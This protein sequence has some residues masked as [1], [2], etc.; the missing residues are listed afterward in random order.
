MLLS[1]DAPISS[2]WFIATIT[3]SE[4]AI[5]AYFY[6]FY[7]RSFTLIGVKY[8]VN[9]SLSITKMAHFLQF[10][11]NITIAKTTYLVMRDVNGHFG[12]RDKNL[13]LVLEESIHNTKS[14]LK[15]LLWLS[16]TN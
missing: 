16:P 13:Y 3:D 4:Q 10:T 1:K 9:N 12:L 11:K 5:A 2:L 8:Y 15:T 14:L 7:Y 6:I